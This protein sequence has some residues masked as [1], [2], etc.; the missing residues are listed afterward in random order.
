MKRVS[1]LDTG[2]GDFHKITINPEDKVKN[3]LN[4]LE[5]GR[6]VLA[7]RNNQKPSH[8]RGDELLYPKIT[9]GEKLYFHSPTCGLFK[10]QNL[11]RG[12]DQIERDLN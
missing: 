6:G 5:L 2:K 7:K 10:N 11:E 8:L 4:R 12:G 9:D 1:I 3:V